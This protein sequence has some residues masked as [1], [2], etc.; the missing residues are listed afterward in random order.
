M[1]RQ[2]KELAAYSDQMASDFEQKNRQMIDKL[3]SEKA[4]DILRSY[5]I[6]IK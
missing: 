2:E 6:E 3:A 1:Y 4:A 5:G